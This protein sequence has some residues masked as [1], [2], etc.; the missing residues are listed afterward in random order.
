MYEIRI[1]SND[2]FERLPYRGAREALGLADAKNGVAYIRETGVRDLDQTTIEHEFDELLQK[3][4]PHEEDGIRYKKM[5]SFFQAVVPAL[6]NFIPGVGSV[7]STLAY[8]ASS[9]KNFSEGNT[10]GGI[11]AGAGGVGNLLQ[12]ASL[13]APVNSAVKSGV[14]TGFK[15][16][17]AN[18]LS[19]GAGGARAGAQAGLSSSLSPLAS[20]AGA[21]SGFATA[22]KQAST[23]TQVGTTLA[24]Q[25]LSD[26]L[27]QGISAGA[28]QVSGVG[29]ERGSGG[30]LDA[31][32]G[33]SFKRGA[34]GVAPALDQGFVDQGFGRIEQNRIGQEKNVLDTFRGKTVEGNS[35]FARE[36]ANVGASTEQSKQSFLN[37]ANRNNDLSFEKQ[38]VMEANGLTEDQFDHYLNI[39]RGDDNSIR[40]AVANDPEDFRAIFKNFL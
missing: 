35:A 33:P 23:L 4:S 15:G 6:L 2:E 14:E 20:G 19:L 10:L 11:L 13:T 40:S 16:S 37:E 28:P 34:D 9:A 22:P 27:K 30:L 36:L 17:T 31:F 26:G 29:T 21:L 32:G 38:S 7:L 12:P 8:A 1:L 25:G 18:A 5:G 39:A 3:V 24:K